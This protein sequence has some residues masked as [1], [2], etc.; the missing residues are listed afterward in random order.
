VDPQSQRPV[1]YLSKPFYNS[2]GEVSGVIAAGLS[3][4]WL[5]GELARV[6][7]PPK[8]TVSMVDRNGTILVRHPGQEQFVGKKIAAQAHSYLLEGGEGVQEASG[9]DG[10]PRIFAYTAVPVARRD[11]TISVGLDKEELLKGSAAANRRDTMVIGGSLIL[12]LILAAV[13]ARTFV[14]RPLRVLLDAAERLRQGDLGTRVPFRDLR[15]EF[16]RLG[17]AFN[18]MATAIGLREQEL[19][20]RVEQRTKALREAMQAQH[21]AEAALHEA[22]KMET[23]GRLTGGVAHD[24]NNLLAVIVGNIE[25]AHARLPADDPVRAKLNAALQGANRGA[26]LVKQLL[27]FARRQ[28]LRPVAVDLIRHVH[29]SQEMLQRLLRSDVAVELHLS[30][31]TW[32]VRAD[33]NQL[34]AAILNLAVN[35]RDA[36]ANGGVLRLST[37]NVHLTAQSNTLGLTGDFVGFTV[38]D[39]GTG[40]PPEILTKVFEPFF[41]TK[42]AGEGS[43]LG[44][45]MVHGFARQSSGSVAIK[46]EL[47]KGTSVTLYLPRATEDAKSIQIE[48]GE[49]V[50]GEG[51]I[52]LVDDDPHVQSV[53]A[54]LLELSGYDVLLAG[55]ASEALDCSRRESER[56]DM[57]VTDLVLPGELNGV[58]LARAVCRERPDLPVLL[59]TG[60]SDALVGEGEAVGMPVLT[61]PFSRS[62]LAKAV[63]EAMLKRGGCARDS[64]P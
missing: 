37:E 63:R 52:L 9:F 13:G 46:S 51:T 34:D 25:L 36:M 6:P 16:G 26:A 42:A 29:E 62:D 2:Q 20:R 8:A 11:L 60:Y 4:D 19:E 56:I 24:F 64:E 40:M 10:I 21:A 28:T 35:A 3:L 31:D 12:A 5:N 57:L 33:P 23:V 14:S 22:Q 48:V 41:T 39:T 7:L 49:A 30:P 44:L 58:A 45:S 1:V 53:T 15:T 27:A 32:L 43:G 47:G 54:Q 61:K 59:I 50:R 17:A 18:S 55:G 38:S